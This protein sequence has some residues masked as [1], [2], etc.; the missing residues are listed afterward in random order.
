MSIYDALNP[1]DD[2]EERHGNAEA[3]RRASDLMVSYMC[4]L[5]RP[6][7]ELVDRGLKTAIGY[8]NKE[9]TLL[10]MDTIRKE[11]TQFIKTKWLSG[12]ED[13]SKY[14]I[15][16]AVEGMLICCRHPA[17]GGG[18]SELVSNF[19]EAVDKFESNHNL[20]KFLIKQYFSD[21]SGL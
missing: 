4:G 20:L 11:L 8:K 3:V 6:L 5:T 16:R 13:T 14:F 9:A 2:F 1:I 21:H 18:A 10:E 17:W 12:G 7:P 15:S 19:L